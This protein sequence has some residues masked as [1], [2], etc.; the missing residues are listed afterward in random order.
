MIFK[1]LGPSGSESHQSHP[2]SF[3]IGSTA[4]VDMGSAASRL[5]LAEQSRV[6]DIFLSH[7][8]LDHSKDLAFFSENIFPTLQ[9]TVRVH[10][11]EDCIRKLQQ[12][13][14]NNEIWPDFSALPS[15]RKS[16]VR[17]EPLQERKTFS[18]AGVEVTAVPVNH[19]GGCVAFFFR[20]PAGTVLYTGDTGPTEEVWE[21]TRRRKDDLKAVLLE[22][23]FPDRL[24]NLAEASG[25]LT[26]EKML[27]EM[28]KFSVVNAPIFAYHLKAPYRE[29]TLSELVR[30]ADPRLKILEAGMKIDF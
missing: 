11:T 28:K 15:H 1:V 14:F 19:P 16:I 26:P 13:L 5:T 20:S 7:A 22:C 24:E 23:S 25:H 17:F 6:T 3:Q 27:A 29:E 12:H 2:C 9:Q 10:A 30:L 18:V 4:L 8:H 21:E